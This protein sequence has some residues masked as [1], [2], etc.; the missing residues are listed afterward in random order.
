MSCTLLKRSHRN[1]TMYV[2]A[3]CFSAV[4]FSNSS[5]AYAQSTL[6]NGCGSDFSKYI[7]PD[8]VANCTMKSAC[9]LHDICYS[10][11]ATHAQIKANP[12]ECFYRS[13]EPG[14]ENHGK[15]ACS[16]M[17]VQ[18]LLQER[19]KRRA[20]CDVKLFADIA[21]TNDDKLQC[22]AIGRIYE[23]AVIVLGSTSFFGTTTSSGKFTR[24]QRANYKKALDDFLANA[25][26]EQII[27]LGDQLQAGG[28]GLD[29]DKPLK[30]D[31]NTG[32]LSNVPK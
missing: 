10:K 6:P 12:Q 16:P 13:C 23:R 2:V 9:D 15:D 26:P 30:Y 32:T 17:K 27:R 21:R 3:A 22:R 18:G 5:A 31:K 29:L 7:V 19:E 1:A 28:T 24:E 14:E 11:C 20:S 25:T 8:R 4:T